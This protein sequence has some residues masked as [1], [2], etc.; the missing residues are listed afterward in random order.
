MADSLEQTAD[1]FVPSGGDWRDALRSA[2]HLGIGAHADDLEFMAFHGIEACRKG[3][4]KF[5]GVVLTDGA[6]SVGG[7][8]DLREMRRAEQREAAKLGGYAAVIQL[9]LTSALLKDG[10]DDTARNLLGEIFQ[11]AQPRIVYAH[12]PADRHDT[13]VAACLRTIDALRAIPADRHPQHVYGCE[14]WRDLDWLSGDDRVRLNCGTDEKFASALNAVFRSQIEGGKRYDL[15]VIGRRR[16]QATFDDPHRVDEAEMITLAMD[17]T[18]LVA[19][20]SLPVEEFT[21]AAIDRFRSDVRDR[22]ARMGNG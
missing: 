15:A 16:A 18:P 9:G 2:T 11:H 20:P 13:H 8:T 4:G 12:N 3:G 22:L 19:D 17:L 6:G 21:L 10:K 1:I 7:G 5:A 14:L